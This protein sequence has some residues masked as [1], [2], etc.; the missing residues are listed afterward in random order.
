MEMTLVLGVVAFLAI[1]FLIGYRNGMIKVLLSFVATIIAFLLSILLAG[2]CE[3]FIKESTP[4]YDNLKKQMT[5][6]VSEYISAEVDTSDIEL[7]KDAIGELKLPSS[8]KNKLIN[9]NTA[10][11]KL[12]M[13]VDTFSEYLAT[14]LA[15][16]VVEVLAVLVLFVIIKLILRIIISLLNIVS[17]LPIIHG[18]NKMLGG[19]VGLAEGVIIIWIICLL[20]TIV[21]GTAVGEQIMSEISSNEILNYIY[22]NNLIMKMLL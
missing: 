2:P 5:E 19:I 10:D 18:I 14:S 16:I 3:T 12:S 7:Q 1:M 15:D 4:V 13:G 21:S 6:Y 20:L 22:S 11:E 9:S 8:I 17:H